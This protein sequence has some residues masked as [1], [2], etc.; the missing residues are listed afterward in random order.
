MCISKY[1]HTYNFRNKY[2][3]DVCTVTAIDS[4]LFST[5]KHTFRKVSK[6]Q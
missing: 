2:Y 6:G 4:S 5:I 3:N 1:M